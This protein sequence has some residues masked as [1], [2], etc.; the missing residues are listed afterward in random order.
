[1]RIFPE[2]SWFPYALPLK[3]SSFSALKFDVPEDEICVLDDF[4]GVEEGLF[5]RIIVEIFIK[6]NERS[7]AYFYIPTE[8]TIKSENLTPELDKKDRWKEE[9]KKVKEV[10]NRFPEL[11][12]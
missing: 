3:G 7:S 8:N 11:L 10:V 5:E 2:Y 12:L 6:N 9:I 4:E 1:M